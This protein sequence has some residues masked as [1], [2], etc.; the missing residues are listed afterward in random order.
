[1][2]PLWIA[3]KAP[4]WSST[5]LQLI[6]WELWNHTLQ[7]LLVFSHSVVS[8]S[9]QPHGL[10]HDKLACPLLSPRVCSNSCPLSRWCH[11]TISS[12]VIHVSSCPQSFPASG[13]FLMSQHF[14]SGGQSIG[15]SASES[16]LPMSIQGWFPLG[17]TGLISLL[18]KG[19][20]RVFPNTTVGVWH[21]TI[22][23]CSALMM[24][25]L[26]HLYMTTGK[27]IA[28]TILT[29][30]GKVASL[31]FNMLS[32]FVVAFL[33]RSKRLL[34]SWLHSQPAVILE[35]KKMKSVTISNFPHLSAQSDG[36]GCHNLSFLN[37]E[38]QISF[39]TLLML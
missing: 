33:P 25:Q 11:P 34:I 22:L 28:F 35:P 38:L 15:A 31:L 30:V 5:R 1:M 27:T 37:V 39:F 3:N 8:D 13:A 21:Q 7:L 12:S 10:Q 26:S 23:W 20:S 6:H 17:L 19:L 9:W 24:V 18:S 32:R 36:T 14:T 29:F 2:A 4:L 16:V